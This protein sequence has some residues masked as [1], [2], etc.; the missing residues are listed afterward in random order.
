MNL[1]SIM[2]IESLSIFETVHG[3]ARKSVHLCYCF[4]YWLCTDLRAS[5]CTV[6]TKAILVI[7]DYCGHLMIE[8]TDE[9]VIILEHCKA[10]G[11]WSK[12][13]LKSEANPYK[14]QIMIKLR[15]VP[16]NPFSRKWFESSSTMRQG[17]MNE[18]S[19]PRNNLVPFVLRKKVSNP[20]KIPKTRRTTKIGIIP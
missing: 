2:K 18:V 11:T 12:I 20:A 8:V 10:E 1:F 7:S 6:M 13:I 16:S 3:A 14:I 17:E 9:L 4:Y 5:P 15:N 19:T